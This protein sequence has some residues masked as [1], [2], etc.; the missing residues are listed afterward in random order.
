MWPRKKVYN[1]LLRAM[2]HSKKCSLFLKV[3]GNKYS[4][5]FIRS[6]YK[7]CFFC[8]HWFSEMYPN[9]FYN[10]LISFSQPEHKFSDVISSQVNIFMLKN[11]FYG[12]MW[13]INNI[14]LNNE[15]NKF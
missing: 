5:E 10:V 9:R 3:T 12:Q 14:K 6:I 11:M 2:N 7:Q 4:S 13:C 8:C 15:D 1:N